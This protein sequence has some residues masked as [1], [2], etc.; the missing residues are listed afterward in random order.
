MRDK[1]AIVTSVGFVM[2]LIFLLLLCIITPDKLFSDNENRQL[3]QMPDLEA[4]TVASGDYMKK[5]E[6]YASDNIADRDGW[7]RIKNITDIISGKKDNGSAYFGRDGYLFPMDNIDQNQLE[8]NLTYVKTFIENVH[9][10]D[11]SINISVLIAPTSAEILKEKLPQYAPVP[12]QGEILK[13]A[14]KRFGSMLVNPSLM[15]L[16]HKD[17]YIYYK[18]DHHWTTLGAYYSYKVWA[19]QN[20]VKPV[21]KDE[22]HIEVVS[23]EFY[24]TTYS[25]AA[26][27]RVQPDYIEKFSNNAVDS[28]G[29]KIENLKQIKHLDSLYDEKYLK[30]KDKYSYFLSG[31]NP[32][33]LIEGTAENNRSILIVK[34][35]YA[36]CFVPFITQNFEN[37]YVVDLRYYKESLLKLIKEKGITDILFLYNAVQYSNDRNL[38]YLLK[39]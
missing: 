28:V 29:M 26:G 4:L 17:E 24:G 15:L 22:F 23:D 20:N 6:V 16:A 14:K 3:Q 1:R 9:N 7:V 38:V 8:K 5:F 35:S 2:L 10:Q 39:E 30:T 11:H 32:M 34:D 25:K 27:F 12:D 19:E 36:N 33:T 37:V 21:N 31:N 13:K 18:T